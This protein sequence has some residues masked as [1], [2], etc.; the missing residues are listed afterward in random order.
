MFG[1]YLFDNCN[2]K[3]SI[4][5]VVDLHKHTGVTLVHVEARSVA[6]DADAVV[7][8][9]RVAANAAVRAVA[10]EALRTHVGVLGAGTDWFHH[11]HA[12]SHSHANGLLDNDLNL[13]LHAVAHLWSRDGHSHW[14]AV[15]GA[16]AGLLHLHLLLRILLVL[17]LH[18][19]LHLLL[20]ILL[21]LILLLHWLLH[22]L[23]L[24]LL[25]LLL[26]LHWL[27]SWVALIHLLLLV[28]R[29]SLLLLHQ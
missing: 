2:T 24:G 20:G 28:R 12:H 13:R 3:N 17:L 10:V 1:N 29:V 14:L 7:A 23:H 6:L 16:V 26:L 11:H 15:L 4:Y 19:L 21:L 9:K 18:R 8:L 22:L 5:S 25:I 27:L